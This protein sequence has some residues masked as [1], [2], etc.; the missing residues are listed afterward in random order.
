MKSG[1]KRIISFLLVAIL[2]LGLFA[3]CSSNKAV[4]PEQA[5]KLVLKDLGVKQADSF[6]Y[7]V[8]TVDGKVCYLIFVS[9]EDHHWQYTV[10]G[11]SGEI[12]EKTET[13]QGHSH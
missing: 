8:T 7:H 10:A 12:L 1:I 11:A 2:V 4:T 5:Q 3:G 6:D 13:A 9:V